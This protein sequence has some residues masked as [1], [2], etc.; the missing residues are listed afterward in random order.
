ML[1]VRANSVEKLEEV[2]PHNFKVILKRTDEI[3]FLKSLLRFKIANT[4]RN[5][6][7]ILMDKIDGY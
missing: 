3:Y 4:F 1:D 5:E 7:E 2:A 6:I